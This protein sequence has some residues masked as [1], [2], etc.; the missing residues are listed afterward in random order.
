MIEFITKKGTKV[1]QNYFI[2][3]IKL[4]M[5]HG[6]R[7]LVPGQFFNVK[8]MLVNF[9]AKERNLDVLSVMKL[10]L[11]TMIYIIL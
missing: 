11:L 6:C 3:N 2:F 9:K 10:E 8:I 1:F 4:V 5:R 7:A